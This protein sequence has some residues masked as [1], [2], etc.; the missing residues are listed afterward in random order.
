[1]GAL[2]RRQTVA[3]L[4]AVGGAAA[5]AGVGF[6]ADDREELV[7]TIIRRSVGDFKMADDHFEALIEDL[8][9][10][11]DKG[12]VR[13][14]LYHMVAI[15]DPDTLLRLAPS[16]MSESYQKY[17]RR[18]VTAF[19]T[20]TDYLKINPRTDAVTFVG[21]EACTSPFARIAEP[22]QTI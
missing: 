18:V 1:M 20:R 19:L 11:H 4:I 15:T 14:A 6:L 12:R 7:R 16:R 17:E 13:F 10:P 5:M 3:A 8:E 21:G 22:E 2:T 9:E